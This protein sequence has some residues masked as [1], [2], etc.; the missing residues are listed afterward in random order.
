M[1]NLKLTVTD[2]EHSS[3]VKGDE[4]PYEILTYLSSGGTIKMVLPPRFEIEAPE[5]HI[6]AESL[7]VW[8]KLYGMVRD[9]YM[10]IDTN[11]KKHPIGP[12]N[13]SVTYSFTITAAG[14]EFCDKLTARASGAGAWSGGW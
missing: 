10:L 3:S 11:S 4:S 6:D 12:I 8:G 5:D 7:E 2:G 13:E 9:G 14:E 1:Q